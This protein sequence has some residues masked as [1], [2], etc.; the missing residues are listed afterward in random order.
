MIGFSWQAFLGLIIAFGLILN[1]A[2]A[3]FKK[4]L[5]QMIS[6]QVAY[7]GGFLSII[8]CLLNV[9][10]FIWF[11]RDGK[12]IYEAP[13][14]LL[15]VWSSVVN[16]VFAA[17]YWVILCLALDKRLKGK[18]AKFLI[19]GWPAALFFFNYLPELSGWLI[20]QSKIVALRDVD[21]DF[22]A[23]GIVTT[24]IVGFSIGFLSKKSD[25]ESL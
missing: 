7:S 12:L 25:W 14:T 5:D 24:G 19:V 1:V 13:E 9:I 18:N 20:G 15:S 16:G 17:F 11:Y 23:T 8:L 6:P 22:I 10:F 4:T 3:G 21:T 2:P